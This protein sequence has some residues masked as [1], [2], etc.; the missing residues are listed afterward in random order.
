LIGQCI[1]FHQPNK[2]EAELPPSV[3]GSNFETRHTNGV[4]GDADKFRQY[5]A[6]CRQLVQKAAPNDKAVLLE[7]S[8]AWFSCAEEVERQEKKPDSK[9]S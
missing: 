2:F 8:N 3:G 7:I 9:A 5:A 4:M 6:E 1:R